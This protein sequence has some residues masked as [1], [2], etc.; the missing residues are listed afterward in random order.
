MKCF[1][2][3]LH[4]T[5]L[6][7][8]DVIVLVF[9]MPLPNHRSPYHNPPPPAKKHTTLNKTCTGKQGK[10]EPYTHKCLPPEKNRLLQCLMQK[11]KEEKNP[12]TNSAQNLLVKSPKARID[13]SQ[14]RI[15]P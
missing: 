4:V 7:V 13:F 15:L 14:K 6:L 9:G 12:K 1:P 8:C 2:R 11:K 5:F 10:E 3:A